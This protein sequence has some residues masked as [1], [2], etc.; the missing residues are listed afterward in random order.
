V[1]D[2]LK[3][4]L[5]LK[6]AADRGLPIVVPVYP[7]GTFNMLFPERV[8]GATIE[9]WDPRRGEL[10]TVVPRHVLRYGRVSMVI[11]PSGFLESV[12]FEGLALLALPDDV[13]REVQHAVAERLTETARKQPEAA[14]KVLEALGIEYEPPRPEEIRENPAI[15][16]EKARELEEALTRAREKITSSFL[17]AATAATVLK[18]HG[19]VAIPSIELTAALERAAEIFDVKP[20]E[21]LFAER[22][23]MQ[24]VIAD[25]IG[26]LAYYRKKPLDWKRLLA[27]AGI[28]VLVLVLF[29]LLPGIIGGFQHMG[30]VR[31]P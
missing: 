21:V 20:E 10:R 3:V 5:K 31:V 28:A 25:I 18:R 16:E 19:V 17:A 11:V 27:L 23:K 9:Y 13:K 22:L 8:Y 26:Q 2:E 14:I 4:A 15:V 29:L 6:K 7:D 12:G 24:G 30:T 1:I